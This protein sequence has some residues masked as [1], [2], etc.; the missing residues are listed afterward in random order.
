LRL[1]LIDDNA[2]G[3]SIPGT[4]I[5]GAASEDNHFQIKIISDILQNTIF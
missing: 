5:I 4:L 3:G 1:E 2:V